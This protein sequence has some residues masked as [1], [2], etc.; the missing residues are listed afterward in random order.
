MKRGLA[1]DSNANCKL[2]SLLQDY[3]DL[4][5]VGSLSL[6]HT[7]SLTY[8]YNI[9]HFAI[10]CGLLDRDMEGMIIAFKSPKAKI[11]EIIN[12]CCRRMSEGKGKLNLPNE[13]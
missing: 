12:V 7:H 6:S 1:V 5:K 8:T 11:R 3:L 2:D 9:M 4:Q 13:N 10:V